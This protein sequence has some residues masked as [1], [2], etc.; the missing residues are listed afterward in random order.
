MG[1][2]VV[3]PAD[4]PGHG[5]EPKRIG[6]PFN[7]ILQPGRPLVLHMSAIAVVGLLKAV[8]QVQCLDYEELLAAYR[9]ERQILKA[10]NEQRAA[11]DAVVRAAAAKKA[12]FLA[13]LEPGSELKQREMVEGEMLDSVA[14]GLDERPISPEELQPSEIP[15]DA[16][17]EPDSA[18]KPSKKRGR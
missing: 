16:P 8:K 13:A 17:A 18:S 1:F 11:Q 15:G 9:D 6:P 5:P 4:L 2:S 10:M 7:L 3:W 12:E 14:S